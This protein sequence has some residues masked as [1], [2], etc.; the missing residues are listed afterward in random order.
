MKRKTLKKLTA[1]ILCVALMCALVPAASAVPRALPEDEI[2][3]PMYNYVSSYS[4]EL[5][6]SGGT[7]TCKATITGYNGTTTK[8]VAEMTLQKKSG[9]FGWDDVETW[10]TSISTYKLTSTKTK[11]VSSG[12][13]RVKVKFTAYSGTSSESF[14]KYSSTKSC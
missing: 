4:T 1:W 3:Q 10:K 9:L 5:T 2:V 13:Y 8:L 7:A 11:S 12:T 14:T 6:I